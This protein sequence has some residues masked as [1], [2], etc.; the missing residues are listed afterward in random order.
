[1]IKALRPGAGLFLLIFLFFE[2]N[3]EADQRHGQT[4]GQQPLHGAVDTQ[5]F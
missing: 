4:D 2:S 1:L 5:Q 3:P